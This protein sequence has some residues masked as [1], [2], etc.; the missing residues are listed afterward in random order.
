MSLHNVYYGLRRVLSYC[1]DRIGEVCNQASARAYAIPNQRVRHAVQSLLQTI[2]GLV[3]VLKLFPRVDAYRLVGLGWAIV[4]IG[5]TRY[6]DELQ[7]WVAL[8]GSQPELL[9]RVA[10]WQLSEATERFLGQV[11]MVVV[12]VSPLL[13]R[14]W[15]PRARTVVRC[16]VWV[17]QVLD[18]SRPLEQTLEGSSHK[19]I[20]DLIAKTKK[21]DLRARATREDADL[22]HFFHE[23]YLPHLLHRH[24]SHAEVLTDYE[25][26]RAALG[27]RGE[28]I[29]IELDGS[30]FAGGTLRYEGTMCLAGDEGVN[31]DVPHEIARYAQ[32]AIKRFSIERAQQLGMRS[33]LFGMSLARYSDP[34]FGVKRRWGCTAIPA[35]LSGA[36]EWT[37]L[38]D[39]LTPA[40]RAHLNEQGLISLEGGKSRVVQFGGPGMGTADD[41]E[42]VDGVLV[43]GEV[44][45]HHACREAAELELVGSGEP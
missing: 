22:R 40:L 36:P 25:K 37:F 21:L 4:Y 2:G 14:R 39:E 44:M 20:R 38:T 16:P 45:M 5:D 33:M 19:R 6:F 41:Y 28:L 26:W 32:T 18:L 30:P 11:D 35:L 15:R 24:G 31:Q 12:G 9:G 29:L 34:V 8:E 10:L 7:R 43:R 42:G 13:P 3:Y 27:K 1:V 23:M 17:N